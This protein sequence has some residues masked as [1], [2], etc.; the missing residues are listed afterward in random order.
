MT[1]RTISLTISIQEPLYRVAD[2][3]LAV[4]CYHHVMAQTTIRDDLRIAILPLWLMV[5]FD[6]HQSIRMAMSPLEYVA[7]SW[8]AFDEAR[9]WFK[10]HGTWPRDW[11]GLTDDMSD[12]RRAVRREQATLLDR[13]I[14]QTIFSRM[15]QAQFFEAFGQPSSMDG[16]YDRSPAARAACAASQA[17]VDERSKGLRSDDWKTWPPYFPGDTSSVMT[18]RTLERANRRDADGKAA[19]PS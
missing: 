5:F 4:E 15:R 8:P 10:A 3:E 13:N 7:W 16:W 19:I 18:R 17:L 11:E 6:Q 14:R 9:R 12:L 2:A 1:A